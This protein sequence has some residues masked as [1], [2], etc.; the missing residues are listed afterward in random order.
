MS[1]HALRLA[2]GLVRA[3]TR[4]YTWCMPLPLRESRCA[5]IESDLWEHQ[6]DPDGGRGLGPAMQVLCRLLIGVPDDLSWRLEHAAE[7]DDL[8]PRRIVVLTAAVTLVTFVLAALWILPARFWEGVPNARTR[9]ND[10]ANRYP[11]PDTG[12]DIRMRVINCAGVFFTPRS[13]AGPPID[14]PNR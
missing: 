11:P 2:T 3:W 6:R 12:S 4:A 1:S 13:N 5:E 10:C 9:V 8:L 7:E 14:R